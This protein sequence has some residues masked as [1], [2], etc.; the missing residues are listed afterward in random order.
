MSV[1]LICT[2]PARHAEADML[3]RRYGLPQSATDA[4]RPP[5]WL[6]LDSERLA[7]VEDGP[8]APGPVAVDWIGG[9]LG[10]RLRHGGGRA[11]PL[12]R[13]IGLKGGACPQVV[14]LT[15]GLG[16]DGC[17][18]AAL[19]C[20]VTLVERSPV[21]AAL[22]DDGLARARA[23][24]GIGAWVRERVRLVYAEAADWLAGREPEA[25]PEVIYLD[26]MYPHRDKSALVK[27]EMRAFRAVVGDDGDAGALLAPALAA[28]VRRVVVKRPKGAPALAGRPPAHAIESPNTRYDVYMLAGR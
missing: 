21:V 6:R 15:A 14:D 1:P 28:A 27:K 16:R 9:A 26:P 13:A 8:D 7:L 5:R 11:Q 18:L 12:A 4:P 10:H 20:R 3:A 23:D 22:L 2:D 17:V 19:G 24:A 25:R